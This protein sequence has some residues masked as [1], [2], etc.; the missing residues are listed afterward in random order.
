M[1]EK[2]YIHAVL[3]KIRCSRKRK[4]EIRK[5]MEA[6]ISFRLS[7]G[8]S[9]Q[10]IIAD[11]GSPEEIATDFNENLSQA[12]KR[13]FSRGRII[14]IIMTV[15]F[16]LAI[17]ILLLY[18]TMPK[19]SDLQKSQYFEAD[20]VEQKMKETIGLVEKEDT[21]GLQE[22]ATT[23]MA[24]VFETQ[25][26][27]QIKSQIAEEWGAQEG[28]GKVYLTEIVSGGAHYA[29]GEVTVNYEKVTVTYR[30]SFDTDMKL[31]GLYV[32]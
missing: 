4:E 8:E 32:R 12:E 21:A 3:K 6:D 25:S 1:N 7:Q 9:V 27:A 10:E 19:S 22:M 14:K 18:L 15:A 11:M 20:R 23:Q 28:T 24:E 31:A 13:A 29:V 16:V 26:I 17:L 30:L 5:Q 2:A